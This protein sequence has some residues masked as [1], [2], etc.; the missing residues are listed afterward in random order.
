[1]SK[2]RLLFATVP[3][4]LVLFAGPASA[5]DQE[6]PPPLTSTRW[7]LVSLNGQPVSGQDLPWMRL[8]DQG[9]VTGHAFCNT[10]HGAYRRLG[11]TL[12]FGPL[13]STRKGCP[14]SDP[15]E[16]AFFDALA[17]T[18]VFRIRDRQLLLSDGI[19]I[20]ATLEAHEGRNTADRKKD[21][22]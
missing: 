6:Q 4:L 22:D 13:V 20:L 11:E 14:R 10:F 19:G 21:H 1:M 8:N 18:A 9:K 3:I 5:M 12:R 17:R 7:Q 15:P 2:A 16:T